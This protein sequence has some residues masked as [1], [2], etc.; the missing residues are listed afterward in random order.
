[1]ASGLGPLL[2]SACN[3]ARNTASCARKVFKRARASRSSSC[4]TT[5]PVFTFEPTSTATFWMSAGLGAASFTFSRAASRMPVA[6]TDAG[7][8]ER[9]GSTA[10]GGAGGFCCICRTS[11]NTPANPAIAM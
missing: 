5:S 3:A 4:S 8:G 2:A 6:A 11:R 7:N 10:G 1:M 9:V